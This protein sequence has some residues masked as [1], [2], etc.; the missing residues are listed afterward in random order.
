MPT[1][2]GQVKVTIKECYNDPHDESTA[3]TRETSLHVGSSY[4]ALQISH[5]CS[6]IRGQVYVLKIGYHSG[7]RNSLM[8]HS[9]PLS[10]GF[11]NLTSESAFAGGNGFTCAML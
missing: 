2:P 4:D 1:I 6:S 7:F 8:L 3:A 5:V 9:M 10:Y 11:T